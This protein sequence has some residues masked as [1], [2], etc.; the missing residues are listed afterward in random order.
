MKLITA[1]IRPYKLEDVRSELENIG[2]KGITISEVQGFG[3]TKGHAE[4]YRGVQVLVEY[5]PKIKVEIACSDAEYERTIEAIIKGAK[6]GG[7]GDGKIFVRNLEQ[8]IRIRTG[9]SGDDAIYPVAIRLAA[10]LRRKLARASLRRTLSAPHS[11][12]LAFAT[13]EAR[14]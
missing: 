3:N 5:I 6:T 9:E 1:I 13:S 7:I 10:H 2:I 14:C 11:H 8:V 12:S 4:N